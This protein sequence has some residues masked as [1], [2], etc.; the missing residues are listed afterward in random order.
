M[1]TKNIILGNYALALS[2]MVESLNE[3]IRTMTN[4]NSDEN[5]ATL[6]TLNVIL[7]SIKA[8]TLN[9]QNAIDLY[10]E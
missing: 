4:D 6:R 1:E 5:T 8:Q 2:S 3:V 10:N 9:V 7:E